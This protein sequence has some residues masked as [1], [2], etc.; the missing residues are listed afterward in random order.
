MP[1]FRSCLGLS[2]ALAATLIL[3]LACGPGALAQDQPI[4]ALHTIPIGA[5]ANASPLGGITAKSSASATDS[6]S[7]AGS[8]SATGSASDPAAQNAGAAASDTGL[9]PSGTAMPDSAINTTTPA[10]SAENQTGTTPAG[11]TNTDSKAGRFGK[12]LK[13]NII[14]TFELIQD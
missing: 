2:G 6:V 5:P 8:T 10:S 12:I 1:V 14:Q 13:A 9:V 11:L 7:S 4:D 3:T